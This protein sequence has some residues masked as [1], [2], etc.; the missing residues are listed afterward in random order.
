M[1][2]LVWLLLA[3]F[4]T[5]F[6][7]VQPVDSPLAKGGACDC[8]A[9]QAGACGMPD[10]APAP[11]A[12]PTA[13]TLPTAAS[14]Q[15]ESRRLSPAPRAQRE[16]YFARFALRPA[17]VPAPGATRVGVP[18]AQVPLYKAHCQFLI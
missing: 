18:V 11:A 10:C 8:C 5:A 17:T 15:V 16:N 4:V 1:K 3:V 14:Q 9:D 6:A 2:R 7:Q 13:L 12:C